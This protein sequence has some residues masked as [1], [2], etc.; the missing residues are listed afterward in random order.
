MAGL[1]ENPPSRSE[2]AVPAAVPVSA[3]PQV[4]DGMVYLPVGQSVE[5]DS[6]EFEALL[7][8]NIPPEILPDVLTNW[9]GVSARTSR[10]QW[11]G[12]LL[13]LLA[14]SAFLYYFFPPTVHE[15][16]VS[17]GGMVIRDV[18]PALP[19]SSPYRP[20]FNDAAEC[21][22]QG[23]YHKLCR[24][25]KPA[26][27]DI[28]RKKDRAS[29][30]LVFLYFRSLRKLH[31]HTGNTAAA[32]L[33]GDLMKQDPDS[34]VWAQLHFEF[35][36]RIQSMLDYEQVLQ[37]L[38]RNPDYRFRIRLH[39]HNVE[40]ALKRLN[41]L[42]QITN[43]GKFSDAEIRK[44]REDYDLFEVKL[45]LSLW[46][47]KGFSAG[48]VTLPDDEY[49]P[50]VFE[51]EKALRIAMKHERSS[52]EDFWLAR[53]FIAKTLISQDSLLNHICWNGKY[54]TSRSALEGEINRCEQRLNRRPQP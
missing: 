43:R 5:P 1:L 12:A 28:I 46:L 47:L 39:E 45:L 6:P 51:R 9:R 42:R 40:I 52:C 41:H 15:D 36:P 48:T 25:L 16:L 49:D 35:S 38:N 10:L 54:H 26:A 50:G 17:H 31:K 21:Y 30:A 3:L 23:D 27:E 22:K 11:L 7:R 4:S 20:L 53:L 8:K 2:A 44:Y 18:F 29:F 13:F 32:A 34:P 37:Q 19:F 33:L 14:S 24:I